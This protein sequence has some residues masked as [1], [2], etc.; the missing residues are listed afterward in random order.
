MAE[1]DQAT[2]DANIASAIDGMGHTPCTQV[3]PGKPLRA[4]TLTLT[5]T[6][7]RN[8]TSCRAAGPSLTLTLTL[9]LPLAPCPLPLT[10]TTS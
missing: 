5:F 6:T 10:L 1:A 8:L 3:E 2:L 4:P 7:D 9:Y